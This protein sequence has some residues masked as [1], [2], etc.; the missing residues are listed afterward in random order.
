VYCGALVQLTY[1]DEDTRIVRAGVDGGRSTARELGLI[2]K[3]AGEAADAYLFVLTRVPTAETIGLGGLSNPL[4]TAATRRRLK[5]ELMALTAGQRL[6]ADSSPEQVAAVR[7]L[8]EE[9]SAYN[10]TTNPASSPL[11]CGTWDIVWTTESELLALTSSGFLGLP[12]SASYQTITRAPLD[13]GGGWAYGLENAI[14]FDG[15]FLRVGSSCSPQPSGGRV[16]F[17]FSSCSAKWREVTLPL[18]PVGAGWFEVLYMDDE[19]RLCR[20]SRADLQICARR[21]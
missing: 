2:A 6:G 8:M 16:D 10:P 18:P 12:W 4:A 5:A 20:D 13:G 21:K 9:L 14:D 15:G 19:L 17:A 11:L 7:A 1:T 3:E